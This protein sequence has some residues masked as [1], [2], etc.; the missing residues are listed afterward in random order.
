MIDWLKKHPQ[1][2]AGLLLAIF[3][4]IQGAM[5]LASLPWHPLVIWGLNTALG[6][7]VTTLAWAKTELPQENPQ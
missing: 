2:T 1:R 6:T 5:A 4:Q 7:V 3:T